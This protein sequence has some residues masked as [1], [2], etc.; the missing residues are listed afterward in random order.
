MK[1]PGSLVEW[2]V[3]YTWWRY[4]SRDAFSQVYHFLNLTEG[5]I[6]ILF[7]GL[8]LARF[9]RHRRSAWEIMYAAAFLTFGLTDFREAYRVE[10]WLLLIKGL[11]LGVLFWLRRLV[12]RRFYP[13]CKIY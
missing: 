10:S 6:W 2:L 8:V 9:I 1:L 11:N 7:A 5:L 12:I 13:H 4:R 3:T